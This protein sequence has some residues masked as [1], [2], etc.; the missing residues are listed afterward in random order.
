MKKKLDMMSKAADSIAKG[1]LVDNVIRGNQAWGL[2]PIQVQLQEKKL[3][4]LNY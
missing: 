4:H 1:D 3:N 2:L